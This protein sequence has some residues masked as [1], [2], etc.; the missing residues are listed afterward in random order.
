MIIWVADGA[1]KGISDKGHIYGT[2]YKTILQ[3]GNIKFV[4]K[5]RP[6]A[7]ELLETMTRGR[8]YVT[9]N[10]KNEPSQ[11]HYFN[12]ELDKNKRIDI[13]Q[14]HQEMK[15]HLHG[16]QEQISRN[17]KKGASK[18]TKKEQQMVDRVLKIWYNHNK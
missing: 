8:I 6:D 15:P 18:L 9:L 1:K 17:G 2:D 11:I 10:S 5:N 13:T 14:S 7:E 4:V 3:S 16:F 12:N